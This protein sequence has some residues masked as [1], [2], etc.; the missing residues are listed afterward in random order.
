M[1]LL[2]VSVDAVNYLMFVIHALIYKLFL[3]IFIPYAQVM[4]LRS[5]PVGLYYLLNIL[6]L[7]LKRRLPIH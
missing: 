6:C 3:N 1:I 7:F 4:T 2:L 5:D